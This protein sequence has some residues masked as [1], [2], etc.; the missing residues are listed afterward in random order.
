MAVRKK[1]SLSSRHKPTYN[2][3]S[4]CLVKHENVVQHLTWAD[5]SPFEP[6]FVNRNSRCRGAKAH[7]I[8]YERKV[9]RYLSSKHAGY[10]PS[11]WFRYSLHGHSYW[12]YCQPDGLLFDYNRNLITIVEI[13]LG[14]SLRAWSQVRNLY[15]PVIRRVFG[16]AWGYAA[17]EVT[18]Y[19]DPAIVFPEHLHYITKFSSLQPM[20]FGLLILR[21]RKLN[22]ICRAKH[23]TLD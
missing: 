7:G 17:C 23:S 19:H 10:V 15:E 12:N 20:Q 5:L 4:R 9:Q 22:G 8:R 13:K 11:P 3:N 1:T 6:S 2:R 14:H 16:K 18:S 21:E